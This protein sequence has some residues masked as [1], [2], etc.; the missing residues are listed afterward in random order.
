[1]LQLWNKLQR[2]QGE[3]VSASQFFTVLRTAPNLERRQEELGLYRLPSTDA[4]W[5]DAWTIHALVT[6]REE[7]RSNAL[8]FAVLL[9]VSFAI[10]TDLSIWESV[11][12]HV[13]NV[14]SRLYYTFIEHYIIGRLGSIWQCKCVRCNILLT[15]IAFGGGGIGHM[16]NLGLCVHT[17]SLRQTEKRQWH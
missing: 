16:S 15:A 9:L 1:M 17:P 14:V 6:D 4:E 7:Q 10:S 2:P 5:I 12:A 13:S 11:V 8:R 3:D